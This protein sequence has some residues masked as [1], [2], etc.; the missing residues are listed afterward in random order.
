M[1][2]IPFHNHKMWKSGGAHVLEK[3]SWLWANLSW[4]ERPEKIKDSSNSQ[5][6]RKGL[7]Y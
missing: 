5:I 4:F 3:D 6:T 2:R 1:H 7:C